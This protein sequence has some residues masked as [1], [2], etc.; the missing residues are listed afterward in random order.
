MPRAM[1]KRSRSRI[2]ASI[3]AGAILLA[4]ILVISTIWLNGGIE[5]KMVGERSDILDD[6]MDELELLE[7]ASL[8]A[9]YTET[10]DGYTYTSPVSYGYSS[11]PV[12]AGEIWNETSIT[13]Y[14][15]ADMD[16][17]VGGG[18][19]NLGALYWQ[20]SNPNV[21]AGFYDSSRTWLG[22]SNEFCRYPVVSG[23]GTTVITVGTYDG[24]RKDSI[25]VNVI[26]PP[27]DQWKREV[28]NLVNAIRSNNGLELLDW[29]YTCAEAA[30]IRA[31]EIITL[32]GHTRPNGESWSTVC[33]IPEYGGAAGENL[34]MGNAAV[35]PVTTTVLWMSSESHR[36]NILSPD[37]TKLAVGFVYDPDTIYRTYWSQFFST[38]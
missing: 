32:Y 12:P 5:F 36:A 26:A 23:L 19:S 38:Y 25:A 28:L 4:I 9:A 34:A 16:I 1:L 21:I 14:A 17:C 15:T 33:P 27:A 30:Q 13:I 29:G 20:T 35:S 37:Y 11:D 18:L 22:Y 7:S 8:Q 6:K 3:G 10:S 24:K 31:E 2:F